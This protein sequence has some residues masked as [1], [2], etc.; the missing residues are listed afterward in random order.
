MSIKPPLHP[1]VTQRDWN[2]WARLNSVTVDDGTVTTAKIA[3]AAVTFAKFQN[4]A[5]SRLL[6]KDA[7]GAGSVQQLGI[8]GG[9]ELSSATLV[10]SDLTGDVTTTSF[11]NATTIAANVVSFSKVQNVATNTIAGRATASSGSLEQ[12]TAD[13][14]IAITAGAIGINTANVAARATG[15]YTGAFTGCTSDPA[16]TLRY[17]ISGAIVSLYM[18]STSATSNSTGFSIT[19]APSAIRPVRTQ[20]SLAIVRDSGTVQIGTVT[21]DSSGVLA[22]GLGVTSG[23]FTNSGGKGME[24]QTITYS[25]D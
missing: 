2:E 19:G 7:S 9:L 1:L 11:G 8:G 12:L 13:S 15:T 5:A 14:T 4:I 20:K 16:P 18:S 17:S 24:L 23:L 25:L 10:R 22:F 6:G 21:M 3:D